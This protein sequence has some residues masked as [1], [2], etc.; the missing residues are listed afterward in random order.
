MKKTYS[1]METRKR[2]AELGITYT[3]NDQIRDLV[4]QY[5]KNDQ[6]DKPFSG[7]FN[8]SDCVFQVPMIFTAPLISAS[9]SQNDQKIDH[10]TDMMQSLAFSV[11][12]L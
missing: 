5:A 9:Q 4:D 1:L 12:I 10:L 8:L 11:R 2:M 7:P 3:K 6:M